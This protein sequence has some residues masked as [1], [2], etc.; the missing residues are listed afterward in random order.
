MTDL[1]TPDQ[2]LDAAAA[3][4]VREGVRG[5][6]LRSV[7]KEAD[8]SLGLLSYH[9]DDKQTL[10]EA[11]FRR[12]TD[13]LL[14]RAQS[15]VASADTPDSQVRAFLRGA[16]AEEFLGSDYLTLRI[17]LWAV[18]RTD[19]EIG[20]IERDLYVR[21]ASSLAA[22]IQG[23]R[24]ELGQDEAAARATDAIVIQ[25]GLWLNWARYADRDALERGLTMCER[26]A[27]S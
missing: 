15:E 1:G 27:L 19:P 20:A 23:A 24:P 12:A 21:Y 2:I 11:A 25:N 14:A 5:A 16:F 3:V 26:A 7:A 17:S 18:S 4:I 9:F 13:V 8:V 6:S 22:L 10:L